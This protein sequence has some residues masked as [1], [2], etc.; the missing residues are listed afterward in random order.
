MHITVML[1][2]ILIS[3]QSRRSLIQIC[4]KKQFLNVLSIIRNK[5]SIYDSIK[6]LVL[7]TIEISDLSDLLL[8][9]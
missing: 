4:L 7:R 5:L 9:D 3:A 8:E 1:R 2:V 6:G